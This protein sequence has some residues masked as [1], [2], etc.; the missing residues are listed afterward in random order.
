MGVIEAWSPADATDRRLSRSRLAA[1]VRRTSS[2]AGAAECMIAPTQGVVRVNVSGTTGRAHV[3][4]VKRCAS[5]WA[6]PRCAPTIRQRRAHELTALVE[7]AQ[8]E[9]HTCLLVTFTLP[10]RA[11]EALTTVLG[12]L[13][14]TWR[15]MWS[16][17][18]SQGFREAWSL[19]GQVRSVEVTYGDNGWHPHVHTVFFLDTPKAEVDAE[20]IG[21][22]LAVFQR[23]ADSAEKVCGRRPSARNGIDVELVHDAQAVGE[24][25][26][27][28][29]GWSIGAEVACQPAKIGKSGGAVTPFGLLG[30]AAMWGD[31]GAR[32]RWLE[33]EDATKGRHAIQASRGLYERYEVTRT[34]DE[35]AAA[36]EAVEVVAT[37]EVDVV[38]W[39]ALVELH[40]DDRYLLAVEEWAALGLG[41]APPSA[42]DVVLEVLD[43][44]R[45][46]RGCP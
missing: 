8:A 29:G 6:C 23:W 10:H 1:F 37:V 35:D 43:E 16:G 46:R 45:C 15:R 4:G 11:D 17:A 5:P 24:Y 40:A 13:A 38:V 39:V 19:L 9:G 20:L 12:D 21:L 32:D 34:D 30:A 14:G 3:Q 26:S 22:W 27:D 44:R 33:Y 36:P 41:G 7:R 31:A 25:V 18:W 2:R 42:R 28:S